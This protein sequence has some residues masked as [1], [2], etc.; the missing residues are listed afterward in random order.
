MFISA[1]K[2]ATLLLTYKYILI[3]P[4]AFLEGHVISLVA[5]FLGRMGYV[6]PFIAWFLIVIGNLIGDIVL[7]YLGLKKGEKL[8]FSWGKYVGITE[9]HIEK[10]KEIFYKH[11]SR[12]LLFSKLS[13][14]FGLAMAI[15]FTAGMTKIPFKTYMFWNVIGE[16]IWTGLLVSLG[17]FFGHFYI[18]IGETISRIG[19]IV[20]TGVII[21]VFF[22]LSKYISS[23]AL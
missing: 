7:Y 12:I 20:V 18:T 19:L 9:A 2:I 22:K 1:A 17:F 21:F 6:N 13:N 8:A 5:G 16:F 4:L 10:S 3:I 11:K 23:K 14:G 15:L